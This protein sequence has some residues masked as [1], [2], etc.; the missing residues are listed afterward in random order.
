MYE[1]FFGLKEQPFRLCTDPKYLFLSPAHARARAYLVYAVFKGDGIVVISG[2]I[3]SGK[4]TLIADLQ[5]RRDADTDIVVLHQTQLDEVEFLQCLLFAMG[6]TMVSGGKPELL[7]T[8]RQLLI[9]RHRQGRKTVLIVDEAQNL[10]VA[11][12]EELRMLADEEHDARK[13]LSLVLVGQNRLRRVLAADALEQLR[14]RIRLRFHLEALGESETGRYIRHR[15][16][17][18]GA[19]T[20]EVFPAHAA[21]E[22][23]RYTGGTPRRINL[24]CDMAMTA[25]FTNGTRVVTARCIRDAAQELGWSPRPL[26]WRARRASRWLRDVLA[27]RRAVGGRRAGSARARRAE[28]RRTGE[29]GQWRASR[30]WI[31]AAPAV[32]RARRAADAFARVAIE[33]CRRAWAALERRVER[34]ADAAYSAGPGEGYAAAL[35]G[36]ANRAAAAVAA[37]AAPLI[38]RAPPRRIAMARSAVPFIVVPLAVLLV[39][40]ALPVKRAAVVDAGLAASVVHTVPRDAPAFR[41]DEV[42]LVLAS[43]PPTLVQAARSLP[44]DLPDDAF[45]GPPLRD[46]RR[47]PRGVRVA[48]DATSPVRLGGEAGL[49]SAGWVLAQ[50]PDAYTIQILG[51]YKKDRLE[52]FAAGQDPDLTLAHFTASRNDRDWHVLLA[53]SYPSLA[54]ARRARSLLPESM[55][56]SEPWIRRFSAIHDAIGTPGHPDADRSTSLAADSQP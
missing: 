34:L 37:R 53:G 50:H 2:E 1:S 13:L 16:K 10:D 21:A 18:A 49:L 3:G 30:L 46:E 17:V 48:R 51:T 44:S 52:R 24:L 27:G 47:T 42:V 25:A 36:K 22:I 6:L 26:R 43:Y 5:A 8:A 4:S 35:R 45:V 9:E 55:R 33:R 54:A 29:S 19:G 56:K 38:A 32:A 39:S 40:L 15:L 28:G 7:D 14:E 11:V 23:Y 20:L 41:P 31:L 12:L